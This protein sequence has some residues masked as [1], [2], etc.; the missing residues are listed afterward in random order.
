ME[1]ASKVTTSAFQVPHGVLAADIPGPAVTLPP[2]A[3]A[4]NSAIDGGDVKGAR[5]T[6]HPYEMEAEDG[7][8]LRVVVD[9]NEN[10]DESVVNFYSNRKVEHAGAVPGEGLSDLAPGQATS[11]DRGIS[12]VSANLAQPTA[13]VNLAAAN[14]RERLVLPAGDFRRSDFVRGVGQR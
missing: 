8:I 14:L 13:S 7:A 3:P 9:L 11:G 12:S 1:H 6:S 10:G 5:A 4:V 2:S